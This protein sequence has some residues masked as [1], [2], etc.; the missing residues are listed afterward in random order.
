MKHCNMI[1]TSILKPTQTHHRNRRMGLSVVAL[2][3]L[4]LLLLLPPVPFDTGAPP[5]A[6]P[7]PATA[8]VGPPDPLPPIPLA[9][10]PAGWATDAADGW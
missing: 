6:I 7:L 2:L 8:A 10:G 3:L 9:P 1:Y 5:F 4:L